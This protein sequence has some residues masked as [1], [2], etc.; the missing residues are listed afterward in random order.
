M[1]TTARQAALD[2]AERLG[3]TLNFEKG[4]GGGWPLRGPFD[5]WA[6]ARASV[7]CEL[8][9]DPRRFSLPEMGRAV[10]LGHPAVHKILSR[11]SVH[12]PRRC[13]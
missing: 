11:N 1:T 2:I 7:V 5:A 13:A 8:A 3:I 10:G 9:A 4:Y 12:R 6:R